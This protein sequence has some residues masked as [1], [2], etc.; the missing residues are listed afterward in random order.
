MPKKF[1]KITLASTGDFPRDKD[2][3]IKGWVEHA[4]GTFAK[5]LSRNVTHLLC[6]DKAWKRYY[7]IG[8]FRPLAAAPYALTR[9]M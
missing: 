1:G 2:N 4:G 9:F 5:E 6:S 8:M 7:P 3:K